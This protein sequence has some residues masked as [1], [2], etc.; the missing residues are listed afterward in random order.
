ML[1]KLGVVANGAQ[2]NTVMAYTS[3]WIFFRK[4]HSVNPLFISIHLI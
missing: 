3:D 4:L 2:K 1:V